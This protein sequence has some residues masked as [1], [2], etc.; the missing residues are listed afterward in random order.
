M[1]WIV[2]A[3][4]AVF[5][6]LMSYVL[7]RALRE[8]DQSYASEYTV[9]TSR[10]LEDMF[11]FISPKQMLFI[12]RTIALFVFMLFFFAAGGFQS[13]SALIQGVVVGGIGA[14]AALLG[15][16]V[17]LKVL[18]VRRLERF[19]HQLVDALNSMSNALKAGFSIQQAF[20]TVVAEGGNPIA[21]EFGMFLQQLRV[22]VRFEEA[23]ADMDTRIGSE[24]LTLMTQAIEISRQT[25]GNL[26]EVFDRIAETI[27]ERHRIEGK[28]KALTAQGKIQGRVVGAM[29]FI[30]AFVL[31]LMDKEMMLSF[32]RSSIGIMIVI[33][34]L[35]MQLCGA[36]LIRKITNVDV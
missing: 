23:L 6:M 17:F 20:E 34:I 5:A 9:N 18:R 13:L 2:P 10:Q 15:Q 14:V 33:L 28:I 29:P 3:L 36:L 31:Y 21:Q 4:F 35:I 16:R 25:G 26:T 8:A 32:F 19:N 1:I 30:L 11:L 22:G 7:L 24:D 27:R 12:S